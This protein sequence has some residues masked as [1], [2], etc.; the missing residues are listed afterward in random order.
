MLS[1]SQKN[2]IR[3]IK[4]QYEQAGLKEVHGNDGVWRPKVTGEVLEGYYLRKEAEAD[5]WNRDKYYFDD[6]GKTLDPDGQRIAINN[7]IAVFGS[8]VFDERMRRVP[9]GAKVAI[10]YCGEQRNPGKKNPTKLFTIMSD[11]YPGEIDQA[12]SQSAPEMKRADYPAAQE[13]IKDCKTFL[14]N[15]GNNNPAPGEIVQY[16]EKLI[17]DSDGPDTQLLSEVKILMAEEEKSLKNEE[18]E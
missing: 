17:N 18:G 13:V 15:E 10:I 4:Q 11:Q 3:E 2:K 9:I 7:E 5:N 14:N 1:Q 8:V 12:S 16:A 6:Q